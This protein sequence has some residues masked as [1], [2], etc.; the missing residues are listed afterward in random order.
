MRRGEHRRVTASRGSDLGLR[1]KRDLWLVQRLRAM[2]ELRAVTC[3]L[4]LV[5]RGLHVAE[6]LK[7]KYTISIQNREAHMNRMRARRGGS[8]E[9][10]P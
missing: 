1:H 2:G 10:C 4:R 3:G 7:Q 5:P 9:D 6:R 8:H